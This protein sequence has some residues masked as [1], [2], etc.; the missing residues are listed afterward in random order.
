VLS[1]AWFLIGLN[2]SLKV[3]L[4]VPAI[5]LVLMLFFTV[6][7]ALSSVEDRKRTWTRLLTLFTVMLPIIIVT[8]RKWH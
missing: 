6:V 5:Y 3:A 7:S 4:I 2:I 8:L 1:Y